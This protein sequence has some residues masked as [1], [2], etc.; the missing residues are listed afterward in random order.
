MARDGVKVF[1]ECLGPLVRKPQPTVLDPKTQEMVKS[2][3]L[4]MV[5][6]RYLVG[7]TKI[8]SLIKYFAVPKREDNIRLVYNATANRLND[9]VWVP[10]FWLPTTDTLVR[11]LHKDSWMTDR[12]VGDMF[13]NFQLH[14]SIMPYTGVDLTLLYSKE[15][16][17]GPRW[18][19][20][21]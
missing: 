21:D 4:K 5:K 15:K 8:K 19:V 17:E 1:F 18:A 6:L 12:D 2:K 9:C 13:L 11:G 10:T 3:I 20:W 16:E 7:D 14:E